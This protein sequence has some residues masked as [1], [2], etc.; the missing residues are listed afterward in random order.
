[1]LYK[2]SPGSSEQVAERKTKL[3]RNASF[4]AGD[5]EKRASGVGYESAIFRS[6]VSMSVTVVYSPVAVTSVTS[7]SCSQ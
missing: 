1:M 5:G 3:Q 6:A 4:L 7:V 2:P